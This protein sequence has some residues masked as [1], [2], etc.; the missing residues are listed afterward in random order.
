MSNYR[1]NFVA[2]GCYFFTV[3][4]LDRKQTL[5]TDHIG[6]LRDSVRRVK[7]LYPF[8][9]DAW[10]VLPDHMHCIWTLPSDSDDYP[11]RWRLIK[12]LFSKGLPNI[13]RISPLRRRRAERG[14]WQRRYWE[15]TL[16]S[17]RDYSRHIDYVHVNPLKHGYVSRVRDWPYSSFHRYVCYATAFCRWTGAEK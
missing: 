7:I 8:H 5:L 15:H 6:L 3:N 14:I 10:V 17:E 1:R 4:L 16:A 13:E 9:I 11:L 12:L 2:G